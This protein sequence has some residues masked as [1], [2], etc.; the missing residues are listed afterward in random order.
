M[1]AAIFMFQRT[2]LLGHTQPWK[3]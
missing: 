1:M 2:V 3:A